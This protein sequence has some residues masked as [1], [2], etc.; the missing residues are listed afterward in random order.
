ME[1]R[2]GKCNKLFRVSD[3]KIT[4]TGIKFVCTRCSEYVKITRE[5]FEH[6]TLSKSVIPSLDIPAPKPAAEP[7]PAGPPPAQPAPEPVRESM[8]EAKTESQPDLMPAP[9]PQP[10]TEPA[11]VNK[12]I[13]EPV[14]PA[15]PAAPPSGQTSAPTAPKKEHARPAAPVERKTVIAAPPAVPSRS[16][17]LFIVLIVALI[18]SGLAGYGV[19]AY[20]TSS[21][22]HGKETA[23]ETSSI[24]GLRISNVAGSMDANGDLVITGVVENTLDQEKTA[25][26]VVVEVYDAQGTVLNKIRLLNGKQ[27]YTRRDYEILAK[28]GVNIQDLKAKTLQ[29]QGVVILPKSSVTFEMRYV[30]PPIGIASFNATL[31]PFDP[32]RLFKEIAEDLK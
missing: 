11:A 4:G 1:V 10:T 7:A 14:R 6:Y 21:S 9:A 16:G 18:L 23:Q 30:Q 26:Y 29:E 31:Q 5:E 22:K 2:C 20:L 28:R 27:L 24:E 13:P 8:P 12:S 17:N 19:Y 15:A 3:D 32:V 25:W